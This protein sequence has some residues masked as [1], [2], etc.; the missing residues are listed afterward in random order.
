ML[1]YMDSPVPSPARAEQEH[2]EYI[3]AAYEEAAGEETPET[4][5]L[6]NYFVSGGR[7]F[8]PEAGQKNGQGDPGSKELWVE[9][10]A[11]EEG[12]DD[13]L[14][15]NPVP[16]DAAGEGFE[17]EDKASQEMPGPVMAWVRHKNLCAR[18]GGVLMDTTSVCDAPDTALEIAEAV[19]EGDAEMEAPAAV[20]QVACSEARAA[21]GSPMPYRFV[22][23]WDMDG[24]GVILRQEAPQMG[25]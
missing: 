19:A 11:M 15:K 21:Q 13:L 16:E 22:P 3:L 4:E 17:L 12:E 8:L 6:G 1:Y 7:I 25:L 14:V 18:N 24:G 5:S 10:G 9:P 2:M 23:S 20:K